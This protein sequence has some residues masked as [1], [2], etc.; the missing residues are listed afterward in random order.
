M[1]RVA[2]SLKI[3]D[4][5]GPIPY[6]KINGTAYTVAYDSMEELYNQMFADLEDGIS[7]FKAALAS[8][9]DVST[10]ADLIMYMAGTLQNG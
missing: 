5:Y 2:A 6:S 10:L 8:G 7:I 1:L 9:A 4:C 3:S